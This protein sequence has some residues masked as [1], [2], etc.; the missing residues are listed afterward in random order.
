MNLKYPLRVTYNFPV[1]VIPYFTQIMCA[2]SLY[3]LF[4]NGERTRAYKCIE[5]KLIA[6]KNKETLADFSDQINTRRY[7]M[8]RGP[9]SSSCGGLW[10]RLSLPFGGK[11]IAFY[12]VL[13]HF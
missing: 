1:T 10:P 2:M 5:K 12:A 3:S 8:L 11:K 7:G 9:T 4:M 6:I 13:V